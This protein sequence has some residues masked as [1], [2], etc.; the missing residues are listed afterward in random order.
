MKH[1]LLALSV[2][3]F[4]ISCTNRK[5]AEFEKKSGKVNTFKIGDKFYINLSEDHS[6]DGLWSIGNTH[7][8]KTIEY[9]NSVYHSTNEGNVD[10]N[11]EAKETGKTEIKF[12]KSIALDT[13]E[14]AVFVVEVK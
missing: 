11:F 2:F 14:T 3:L 4:L 1:T 13:M 6:K 8:N 9:I 10:F 5:E 12:N 7:N